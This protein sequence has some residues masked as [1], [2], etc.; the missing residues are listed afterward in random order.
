M[1]AFLYTL[2]IGL[3]LYLCRLV[4][5]I[6]QAKDGSRSEGFGLFAYKQRRDRP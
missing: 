5:R 3:V 4:S 6:D 1:E 2:D